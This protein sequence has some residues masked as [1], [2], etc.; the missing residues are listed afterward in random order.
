MK[1]DT[2]MNDEMRLMDR[3]KSQ[4]GSTLIEFAL[5]VTVSFMMIFAVVDFSRAAYAYHFVSDAARQATRAASVRGLNSCGS[6]PG[7]CNWSTSLQVLQYLYSSAPSGLNVCCPSCSNSCSSG[8]GLLQVTANWPR[9]A[10]SGISGST[11][12][13][14]IPNSPGC[15][16]QVTVQYTYGFMLPFMPNSTITMSSTSEMLISQ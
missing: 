13:N 3:R 12:C 8:A 14:G 2:A 6:F 7:D 9:T 15:A 4:R 11:S 10:G 1:R 5:V 16:V